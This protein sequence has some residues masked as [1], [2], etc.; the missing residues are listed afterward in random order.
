MYMRLK[1][2]VLATIY[3]DIFITIWNLLNLTF[4]YF[5]FLCVECKIYILHSTSI[6]QDTRSE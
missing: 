6:L 1:Q 2:A 3:I 5:N 4:K